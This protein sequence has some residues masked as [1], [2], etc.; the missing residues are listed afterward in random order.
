MQ[1]ESFGAWQQV[2]VAPPFGSSIAA[3]GKQPMEHRQVEGPFEVKLEAPPLEQRAQGL[4]DAAVVPQ[5]AE[6]QVGPD[7]AHG[8]RLGF[9]GRMGIQH[10]QAL[11]LAH[12]RAHQPIQLAA[13]LQQI[14]PAQGGNDL[15]ADFLPFPDALGDLEVTVGAGGCDAEKHGAS[16]LGLA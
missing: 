12:P 9:T 3:A 10:R 2:I 13:L 7:S 1:P 6:D 5:A 16:S 14:Q 8:H 15:L 11:A 4:R